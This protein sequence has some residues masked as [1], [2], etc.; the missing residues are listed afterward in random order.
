MATQDSGKKMQKTDNGRVRFEE[1]NNNIV[2]SDSDGNDILLIGEREDGRTGL[3]VMDTSGNEI[4]AV[5][6]QANGKSNITLTNPAGENILRIGE[7]D[8]GKVGLTAINDTG[9]DILL[10]GEREDGSIGIDLAQP[11]IDV[12]TASDED[13]I[14]SSKFNSFKIVASGRMDIELAEVSANISGFDSST[15]AESIDHELG[16]TPTVFAFLYNA[17]D[18][19]DT[20]A[21]QPLSSGVHYMYASL[22]DTAIEAIFT[23][24]FDIKVSE[25]QLQ[26]MAT[27]QVKGYTGITN[28]GGTI[29]VIQYYLCREVISPS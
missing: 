20:G 6:K 29:F 15:V 21:M 13:L 1:G 7:R 26:I 23:R 12:K 27:Q 10:I 25:T 5:G 8:S 4:L 3:T 17:D 14:W 19:E 2:V 11:G 16:Y 22:G 9:Q 18:D 24:T 28:F